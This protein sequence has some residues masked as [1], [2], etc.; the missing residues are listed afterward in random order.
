MHAITPDV[1]HAQADFRSA[2][3]PDLPTMV[4]AFCSGRDLPIERAIFAVAGPVIEGRVEMTC[5]Q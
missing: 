4:R 1:P 2:D 3:Y 5:R